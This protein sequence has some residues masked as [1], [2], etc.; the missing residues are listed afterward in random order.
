MAPEMC[1]F[2]R[3]AEGVREE[4]AAK[5]RVNKSFALQNSRAPELVSGYER[6]PWKIRKSS[7]ST[8]RFSKQRKGAEMSPTSGISLRDRTRVR[9]HRRNRK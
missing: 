6:F 2:C 7:G 3:D 9:H 1:T 4:D 8:P 5:G